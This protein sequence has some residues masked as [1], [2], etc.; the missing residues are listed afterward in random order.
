MPTYRV[1]AAAVFL[2]SSAA[3]VTKAAPA[4]DFR[5]DNAIYRDG[6]SQPQSQ[7][8]TIF[9]QGVVYDFLS[10]PA[11]VIIFDKAHR[12]FILIDAARRV[13]SQ[14]S[15]EDVQ[16]VV[17][18][19]KQRLSGHANPYMKWL[20][21]PAFEESFSP[22]NA[23][24]TLRSS[25][26]TYRAQVQS[27]DPEVAAQ[28]HEFSDWYTKLN[29]ALTPSSRPPFPRMML[30]DAID[31]H[32]GVAKE[33]HLTVALNASAAPIKVTSRHQLTA[34]LGTADMQRV[35]DARENLR[36]FPNVSL[37]DYRQEK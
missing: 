19:V 37:K 5:V 35:T 2:I 23:E 26:L 36:S 12:R 33:V 8:V 16:G 29:L 15:M 14:I 32:K 24:L 11:E 27:T 18:R 22:E 9:H 6:Q 17:D 25:M 30:N 3:L 34:N 20:A 1:L 10:E 21:D 13:R 28:Y 31:R 7:G 4:A